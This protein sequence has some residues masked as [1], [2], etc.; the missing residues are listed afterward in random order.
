M[1]K[2]AGPMQP[3]PVHA[4]CSKAAALLRAWWSLALVAVLGLCAPAHATVNIYLSISGVPGESTDAGHVGWTSAL[5]LSHGMQQ[6]PTGATL[7]SPL[8]F[9]KYVDK[10]SPTLYMDLCQ[11]TR[12]P[13]TQIDLV[14]NASTNVQF[15]RINLTN[16]VVSQVQASSGGD[17]VYESVS[18]VYQQIAWTYTSVDLA[19]NPT[20]TNYATWN[21]AS[22]SGYYTNGAY[23]VDSDGDGIPDWWMLQYFGH[24]TGLASDNTLATQDYDGDGLSNY[25]EYIAGTDPTSANSVF[26]VSKIN[27]ASGLARVT[28]TSV[29]GKTYSLYGSADVRGPY[30]LITSGIP[31]TGTGE[32]YY[33]LPGSSSMQFFRVSVP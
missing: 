17:P 20:S 21:L 7:H 3:R 11:G 24:P 10:G 16:V 25:Q 26:R 14:Q 9:Q 30:A 31:S 13:Y 23:A 6:L 5:A 12:I 27:L 15:Y 2:F 29:A 28:W 32:T 1:Q 33:D 19:G 4:Q 22:N 8:T 18:L